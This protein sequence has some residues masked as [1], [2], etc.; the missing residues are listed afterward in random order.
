VQYA[1]KIMTHWFVKAA[2]STAA[3][4]MKNIPLWGGL[5][6]DRILSAAA[7]PL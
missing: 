2:A 1:V 4:I 3:V 5:P 7:V 6:S